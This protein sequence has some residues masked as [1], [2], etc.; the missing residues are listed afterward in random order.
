MS[1]SLRPIG[2]SYL[3]AAIL[4]IVVLGL[5]VW[6]YLPRLRST[7]G[8]W[9]WLAL[10]LRIAAILL[11][12]VAAVRP[13]LMFDEKKKQASTVVLL[14]DGSGSMTIA[15][16][17]GAQTRWSV[18]RK[19]LDDARKAIE[20]KS[21]DLEVKTYKFDND[22]RDYKADDP[23]EPDGRETQLGT[24][25]LKAK[26][27]QGRVASIVLISDGASNGGTSPLAAAQQLKG[28]SIP[29]ITVGVGT[30]NAGKMSK[31]LAARDFV[32]G[33]TVFVK[34]RPEIRANVSARGFAGQTIDV[35]LYVDDEKTPVDT[36]SIK[37]PEGAEV[38]PV[39][40]LKYIPQQPGEKRMTLKVKPKPGELVTTNNDITTYLDVLSGGLKVLYIQGP[41]F[42]WEPK[43]LVP[44]L[45]AAREIH[46]DLRVIREPARGDRGLLDDADL[47]PGQYD[48]FILAGLPADHLT[49]AQNLLITQAVEKGAGLIMLGGRSSFGPGN[50]GRTPLGERVL[51]V[52]VLTTDGSIESDEGFKVVPNAVGLE[53]F[54]LRLG[55]TAAESAR[56]WDS[57]APITGTSLFYRPK[58]SAIFLASAG[59]YPLMF[60]MEIGK[61]RSLAF[62]G[63][64][65]PWARSWTRGDEGRVAHAKFWRQAV[66]WLAHRENKGS[67]QVKLKLDTRRVAVGQKVELTATARDAKSEPIPT[68]EFESTITR[69][70]P[71][72]KPE[73]KAETIPTYPQGDEAKGSYFASGQPG[74]YEVVVKATAG[75]KTIGTDR[76]RFMIY[77]DDREHENP[78]ADLDLLKQIAEA[79]GG[80]SVKTE[81]LGAH[82]KKVG[83]EASDYVAQTELKLWDNWPFF[84]IFVALLS[85]EWALRKA[86]GWV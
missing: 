12:L 40:G 52:D 61:G 14:I 39:T 4:G 47:A 23:K 11:C 83:P 85:A 5:T 72:G 31:D 54:V 1:M 77:Q 81:D 15:D 2:G 17:L 45:D 80:A 58:A 76:A 30:A 59:K 33:P 9:R 82:L 7:T 50:W 43:Y 69:V 22:L 73:G 48:V 13:S 21:K 49:R 68:A 74:E 24:V 51:P 29:V 3:L 71:G 34:N 28:L 57:L 67:D 62:G 26:E 70:G 55:P 38:V 37:V 75:G 18:A 32:A 42:S 79:T 63:E 20:G 60:G 78:A 84:L 44:A 35:E 36:K 8:T 10:G 41:D 66:L 65:W 16:E 6:A 53:N 56:I 27:N 25:L 64:T 19:A 46:A 86:K